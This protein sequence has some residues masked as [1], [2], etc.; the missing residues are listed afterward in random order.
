LLLEEDTQ[1][2]LRAEQMIVNVLKVVNHQ[3]KLMQSEVE[4]QKQLQLLRELMQCAK[5]E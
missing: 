1:E 4:S 5:A 2:G 3:E